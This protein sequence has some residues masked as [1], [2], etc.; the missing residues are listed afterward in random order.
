MVQGS[1]EQNAEEEKRGTPSFSSR[2][3]LGSQETP[4]DDARTTQ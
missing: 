4:F 3:Q 2:D 1:Q